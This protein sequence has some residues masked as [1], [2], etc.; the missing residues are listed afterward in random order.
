VTGSLETDELF[1]DCP[2]VAAPELNMWEPQTAQ[3]FAEAEMAKRN[4]RMTVD[5]HPFSA[6]ATAFTFWQ[7]QFSLKAVHCSSR[8]C[9]PDKGFSVVKP[10]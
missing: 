2:A 1:L 10:E 7:F 4:V 9:F 5:V 6:L 8:C 3:I